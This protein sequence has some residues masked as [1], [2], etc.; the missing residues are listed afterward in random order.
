MQQI[1]KLVSVFSIEGEIQ[2]AT[3]REELRVLGKSVLEPLEK[4]RFRQEGNAYTEVFKTLISIGDDIFLD[5]GKDGFSKSFLKA[6]NSGANKSRQYAAEEV[7]TLSVAALTRWGFDL[8]SVLD[9]KILTCHVCNRKSTELRVGLCALHLCDVAI[10]KEHSQIIET[11]FGLFNGSG[12]AW[13]CSEE[14]YKQANHNH[15]DWN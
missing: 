12:G 11:R 15:T 13:F 2:C 7:H 1:E 3:A 6:I 14:H 5:E 8:P 9:Q 4:L 10:C